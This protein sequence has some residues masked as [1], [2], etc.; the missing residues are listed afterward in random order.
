MGV[1]NL[2]KPPR[3]EEIDPDLI[4]NVVACVVLAIDAEERII[5]VNNAGEQL[6][7][8]SAGNLKRQRLDNLIPADSPLFSLIHQARGAA[9]PVVE[10][11]LTLASP[12]IGHHV[13]NVQAAPLPEREG[14][15]VLS[16]QERFLAAKIDR[17]LTHR[18]AARSV[19]AMAAMLAHEVKNPLAGI[20]GAAQLLEQSVRQE[21]RTLTRLICDETD[22]VC[23]LVDRMEVF[24]AGGPLQRAA[25]NIHEVLVRVRTLA[26]N[27]FGR[28]LHFHEQFD[29]SLPD[30]H[31][32]RDQ[33]VQVFLNLV[34][35]AAEAAPSEAGEVKISTAYWHGVRF[36]VSANHARMH[37]PLMVSIQDNGE[38]IPEDLKPHLFEPFVTAKAKGSGLGLA[39]VAKIIGD[40]GG[41]VEFESERKRTVFRVML[42]MYSPTEEAL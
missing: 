27:S 19:G 6:F 39:M 22:R 4:L 5:Y 23:A 11:H 21:D 36:A 8:S 40:H 1:F 32:N 42:P 37:L 7:Q 30:V 15:V 13:V 20:R 16:M 29:P 9:G 25:V 24:S 18:G 17:Q 31:G 12:R 10:Y 41:V 26:E 14:T 28:H 33:L 34:K 38:G 35:N 3:G 2:R